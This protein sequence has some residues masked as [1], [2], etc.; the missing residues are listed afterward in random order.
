MGEPA[1]P[2]HLLQTG[3]LMKKKICNAEEKKAIA[4]KAA[5]YIES[6]DSIIIASG[7]CCAGAGP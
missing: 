2:I 6:N 5:Q 1:I 7:T 3:L 4:V